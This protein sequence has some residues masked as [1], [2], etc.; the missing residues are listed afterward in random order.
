MACRCSY[1]AYDVDRSTCCRG[2]CRKS[3]LFRKVRKRSTDI[4]RARGLAFR[5][6]IAGAHG[7]VW[8]RVFLCHVSKR[9]PTRPWQ[10]SRLRTSET[11]KIVEHDWNSTSSWCVH[12]ITRRMT[13]TP[14]VG[15]PFDSSGKLSDERSGRLKRRAKNK[16]SSMCVLGNINAQLCSCWG[17]DDKVEPRTRCVRSGTTTTAQ[18]KR[19]TGDRNRRTQTNILMPPYLKLWQYVNVTPCTIVCQRLRIPRLEKN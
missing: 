18:D 16:M 7:R 8:A 2:S 17:G 3:M 19:G 12:T 6:T 14:E 13:L 11:L 15:Q 9:T 1:T 5:V 10:R 4:M